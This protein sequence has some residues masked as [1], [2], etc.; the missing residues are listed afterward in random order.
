MA[1]QESGL[2]LVRERKL[3]ELLS[4]SPPIRVLEASGVVVK[5]GHYLVV[6]DNIRRLARIGS[7]LE[8]GSSEHA[9]VG[10]LREGEGYEDIAYSATERRF[11]ALIEAEKHPDGTY[12]AI[13]EEYDAQ[14]RFKGRHRVNVPF[15]KRNR[16][17]EGLS[18]V[19][20]NGVEYLLALC[21]GNEGR[22][23]VRGNTPG[24]GRIHVLRKGG[25]T[26]QSIAQIALPSSLD[27]K[28]YSALALRGDRLVVVS[29]KS[30]R[31]WIGKLRLK[32]WTIRGDGN[33]YDFPRNEYGKRLYCTVEG[34]DWLSDNTFVMVSDLCKKGYPDRCGRTDQSIHVFRLSGSRAKSLQ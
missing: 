34:V 5:D 23:G 12:K 16:G 26:W 24:G 10:R 8:P 7:N 17:F 1:R 22:A 14:F 19:R 3:A 33:T 25:Q 29:Q 9:W 21:E 28:D 4:A 27:F 2:R 13:I 20:S 31:M 30:A 15:E 32:D 18:A 11:Y 6:F